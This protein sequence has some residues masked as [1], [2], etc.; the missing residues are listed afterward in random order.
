MQYLFQAVTPP[1]KRESLGGNMRRTFSVMSTNK[2]SAD[3]EKNE[4]YDSF[5]EKNQ[6]NQGLLLN[7][8]FMKRPTSG[9]IY[10]IV[11]ARLT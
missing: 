2:S 10:C 1:G 5:V 7:R 3:I 11:I 9:F 6:N 8:G 4:N